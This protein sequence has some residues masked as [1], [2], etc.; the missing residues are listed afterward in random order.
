MPEGGPGADAIWNSANDNAASVAAI[1]EIARALK[2]AGPA[3]RSMLFIAFGAEEHGMAG[4]MHY[5]AH[6]IA[7]LARHVAMVNVEKIGRSPERPLNAN[8]VATSDAWAGALK[9]AG[10]RTG[11]PV[12]PA[13]PFAIPDSDHY[14]FAASRVPAIMILVS[15]TPDSHLPSDTAD[16]IDGT[17]LAS[18][19]NLVM[20]L[21]SDL[22]E[23][24]DRPVFKPQP[25]PDLGLI[26]HLSTPAEADAKGVAAPNAGLKVTGVVAGLPAAAVGLRP[27]DLIVDFANYQFKRDD[28]LASLMAMHREV[29]EGKRGTALPLKVIRGTASLELVMTLR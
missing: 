16:K 25:I 9:S 2:Q 21:A 10:D 23:R 22:A 27:G 5:A 4:S 28:T 3:R 29:L 20:Q 8:G 19:A 12:T 18:A 15:G 14:P 17:R 13:N 1:L 11:T 7:P 26:A 6:P 24:P